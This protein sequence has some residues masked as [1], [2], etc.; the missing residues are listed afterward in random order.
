MEGF[1]TAALTE[2]SAG[3]TGGWDIDWQPPWDSQMIKKNIINGK[4]DI[5]IHLYIFPSLIQD[6]I[7]ASKSAKDDKTLQV[8]L[9][10]ILHIYTVT[11]M[12]SIVRIT[13]FNDE[14]RLFWYGETTNPKGVSNSTDH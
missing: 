8:T 13:H 9:L 4:P 10:Y 3:F 6:V 7:S 12:S 2:D 11:Y 5:D 14:N 1:S